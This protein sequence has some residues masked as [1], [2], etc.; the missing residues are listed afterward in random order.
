[1][2]RGAADLPPEQ[3]T[4][5]YEV[6]LADGITPCPADR[7]PLVRALCG[8]SVHVELMIQPPEPGRGEVYRSHGTAAE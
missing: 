7:L 3:W 5:H 6:F 8:E 4:P 2:G 1:M